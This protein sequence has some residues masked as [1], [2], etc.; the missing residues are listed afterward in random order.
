MAG[1]Y[2]LADNGQPDVPELSGLM[3]LSIC[4]RASRLTEGTYSLRP[5]YAWI[6]RVHVVDGLATFYIR[7]VYDGDYVDTKA[8]APIE[9][10]VQRVLVRGEGLG[11]LSTDGW[12]VVRTGDMEDMDIILT[13]EQGELEPA[14]V[15]WVDFGVT[16]TI[17]RNNGDTVHTFKPLSGAGGDHVLRVKSGY[18]CQLSYDPDRGV[19]TVD[20]IP[21]GGAG[22]HPA[23]DGYDARPGLLSVNG[24]AAGGGDIPLEVSKGIALHKA[25]GLLEIRPAFE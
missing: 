1:R 17:F 9:E 18:N 25:T 13:E 23:P 7:L 14:M 16:S 22:R 4:C 19:L 2:P 10:G 11:M 20:G 15:S 21:G 12:M 5:A 6:R 24:V 8:E 3:A